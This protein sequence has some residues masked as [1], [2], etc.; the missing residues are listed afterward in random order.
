MEGQ[1]LH[2]VGV[3]VEP[4]G[5]LVVPRPRRVAAAIRWRSQRGERRDARTARRR[6]RRAAAGRRARGRSAGAR[7]RASASSRAGTC[8][9]A[10]IVSASAATPLLAQHARP[11]VQPLVQRL[12][13][14]LAG[15]REPGRAS[16][17]AAASA[18][19]TRARAG[20]A[21]R[22]SACSSRCQSRA[23]AVANTLPA[24][25]ITAGTPRASSSRLDQRRRCGG[26][27][28]ARRRRRARPGA[29]RSP[30]AAPVAPLDLGAGA[31]AARRR[32]P[33]GRGRRTRAPS[34]R[35]RVSRSP[36]ARP[37]GSPR[38]EQPHPQ[39]ALDGARSRQPL[40]ARRR[41]AA[42]LAVDDLPGGRAARAPN[43][44][45]K[46]SSSGWSLRRLTAQRRASPRPLVRRAR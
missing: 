16:S 28:P 44:A 46:P 20:Y 33:R 26:C 25:L 13:L 24:P 31:A 35:A 11:G 18:P 10:R 41:R 37:T 36:C 8:S 4:P 6:R 17:R 22:S 14:V 32:R 21:G 5:E 27:A 1:H 15:A 43:S 12:E 19:P 7:R 30:F 38:V 42:T 23:A 29:V 3:G 45:S 40:G 34:P 2:G 9:P 39:R